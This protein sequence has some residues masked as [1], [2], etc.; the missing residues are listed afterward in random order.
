MLNGRTSFD[1]TFFKD[2]D[3]RRSRCFPDARLGRAAAAR[4]GVRTVVVHTDLPPDARG[5]GLPAPSPAP[6]R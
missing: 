6:A 3:A 2:V 4:S 5:G 1:P